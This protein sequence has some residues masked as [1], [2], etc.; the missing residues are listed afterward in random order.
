MQRIQHASDDPLLDDLK[1]GTKRTLDD[2]LVSFL[3]SLVNQSDGQESKLSKK[4]MTLS[5]Q[6]KAVNDSIEAIKEN[7]IIYDDLG[8]GEEAEVA[9]KE[10]LELCKQRASIAK[11]LAKPN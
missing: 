11:S 8:M 7:K 4:E 3:D 2:S 6:L 5:D 1:K 10:L 9:K